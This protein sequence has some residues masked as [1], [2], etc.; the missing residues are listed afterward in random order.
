MTRQVAR[1]CQLT[2]PSRR[3]ALWSIHVL[4]VPVLGQSRASK[5]RTSHWWAVCT[6]LARLS[7]PQP[8]RLYR[9]SM[10]VVDV[11]QLPY[12]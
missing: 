9:P 11:V 12:R 3:S 7:Q 8:L 10:S 2:P 4:R 6:E 5:R 1:S